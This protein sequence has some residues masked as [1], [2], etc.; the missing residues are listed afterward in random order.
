M[1]DSAERRAVFADH[2]E[3]QGI[4]LDVVAARVRADVSQAKP[5]TEATRAT[6]SGTSKA[7][8]ARSG[9]VQQISGAHGRTTD[10]EADDRQSG[11][12]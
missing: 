5:A 7:R 12:C 3:R 4:D 8:R 2:L 1:Y 9:A 10:H 11:K 6:R